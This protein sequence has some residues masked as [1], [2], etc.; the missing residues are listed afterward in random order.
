MLKPYGYHVSTV[1]TARALFPD[2]IGMP[3]DKPAPHVGLPADQGIQLLLKSQDFVGER[4]GFW[5]ILARPR[6]KTYNS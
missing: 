2:D 1:S 4:H 3:L 6:L 5:M